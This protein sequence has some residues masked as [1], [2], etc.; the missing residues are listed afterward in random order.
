MKIENETKYETLALRRLI[1]FACRSLGVPIINLHVRIVYNRRRGSAWHGGCAALGHSEKRVVTVEAEPQDCY[2]C[3][4]AGCGLCGDGK[5]KA[6][7]R[8]E[9]YVTR[10]G[11]RMTLSLPREPEL[12]DAGEFAKTA[13]HEVLHLRGV[14]HGEMTPA[15]RWC[16]GPAPAWAAGTRILVRPTKIALGAEERA[17][18]R[19]EARIA[20][21]R[22]MVATWDMRLKRAKTLS[23]KW[24][25]RLAL[26]ERRTEER[27]AA[28]EPS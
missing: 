5:V 1:V 11:R 7:E 12:V 26:A 22:K 17:A 15:Q 13:I 23:A 14:Q 3:R 4:G 20:H 28:K 2:A 19:A 16:R 27:V 9:E 18:S 6:F 24:R 25:R 21:L 10:F 8:K